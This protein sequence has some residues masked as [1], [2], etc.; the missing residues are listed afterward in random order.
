[1]VIT[2]SRPFEGQL[3][4]GVRQ[5]NFERGPAPAHEEAARNGRAVLQP[6]I[7]EVLRRALAFRDEDRYPSVREFFLAFRHAATYGKASS[8]KPRIFISYQRDS[9]SGWAVLFAR[10][11]EQK[12]GVFAFVDTQRLDTAVRFPT[13]LK[14]AIEECDVFVCLLSASTL[15]SKWVQEE[16]RLAW[17]SRKAMVPVFQE[18]FSQ[19]DASEKLEPHIEALISYDGV[20]LLDRR[21][22]HVDY[23]IME[24]AK[25]VKE[26]T[27]NRRS[28]HGTRG[29]V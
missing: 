5:R 18:S 16:I 19:P 2:G 27:T 14:N 17:E 7:S 13:R 22:I 4:P 21:N 20:H 12:H 11:L 10:E 25:I 3:D 28:E 26:S 29:V 8:G 15:Q 24:L 6:A 23:T 9:S 1:M